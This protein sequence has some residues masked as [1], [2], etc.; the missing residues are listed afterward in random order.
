ML[1]EQAIRSLGKDPPPKMRT[2]REMSFYSADKMNVPRKEKRE[3]ALFADQRR[4]GRCCSTGRIGGGNAMKFV[5][6]LIDPRNE[7]PKEER[8]MREIH[9]AS[10]KQR[11]KL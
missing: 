3:G 4:K 11:I 5:D 7:R 2:R 1:I 8:K 6:E 9:Q 10:E